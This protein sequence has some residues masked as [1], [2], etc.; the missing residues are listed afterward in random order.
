MNQA[1][2][3]SLLSSLVRMHSFLFLHLRKASG[4]NYYLVLQVWTPSAKSLV[5]VIATT[6]GSPLILA[7]HHR[8][9]VIGAFKFP[10]KP[11]M[12][13]KS[14]GL[15][16]VLKGLGWPLFFFP[17]HWKKKRFKGNFSAWCS[18]GLCE[19][20]CDQ[21]IAASLILPCSLLYREVFKPHPYVLR[22]SQQCPLLK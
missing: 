14:R 7:H 21:H 10:C 8:F 19:G 12:W 1:D 9:P 15:W 3:H 22:S 16:K 4:W 6:S 17:L 11:M 20:Q 13:D 5:L 2:L 18:T